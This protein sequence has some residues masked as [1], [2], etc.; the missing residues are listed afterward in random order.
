LPISIHELHGGVDNAG[1]FTPPSQGHVDVGLG[2][3]LLGIKWRFYEHRPKS[4]QSA[5][6]ESEAAEPN[7][8]MGIYPQLS[9]NNPTSSVR[10]GIVL[11]GPQFLLPLV[12]NARV[13]P[14]RVDGEV[15]Y[16]FTN[17]HALSYRVT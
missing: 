11:P 7:F 3:S 9:L 8:S 10:R 4:S 15:G 1:E 16:C 6:G 5:K 14:L 2:E 13:G 17:N 12:A